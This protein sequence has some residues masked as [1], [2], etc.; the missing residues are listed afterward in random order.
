MWVGY[1]SVHRTSKKNKKERRKEESLEESDQDLSSYWLPHV[2]T[3]ARAT[4]RA[5]CLIARA[6]ARAVCLIAKW[7]LAR[8]GAH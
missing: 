3:L 5:V 8:A 4:A 7:I 2:D 6:T 1:E